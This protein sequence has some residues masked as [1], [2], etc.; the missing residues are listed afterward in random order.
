M[1]QRFAIATLV[2]FIRIDVEPTV[3]VDVAEAEIVASHCRVT[4]PVERRNVGIAKSSADKG[5]GPVVIEQNTLE[6]LCRE[7]FP[8]LKTVA[9]VRRQSDQVV[10]ELYEEL[11]NL[12]WARW[13]VYRM[14]IVD[15]F[16]HV[17]AAE[18]VVFGNV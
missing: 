7:R 8:A 17:K 6:A 4:T 3:S 14:I 12:D 11:R 5:A 13:R 2:N 15:E 16:P 9:D 10:P 18:A 1:I